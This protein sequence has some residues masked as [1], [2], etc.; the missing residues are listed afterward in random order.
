[1]GCY[2]GIPADTA[3]VEQGRP[4]ANQAVVLHHAAVDHRAVTH[5][6]VVPDDQRRIAVAMAEHQILD[7][8]VFSNPD[9]R[10]V[11]AQH[12]PIPDA[13]ILPNRDIPDNRRIFR[14]PGRGMNLGPF[15]FVRFYNQE[16]PSFSICLHHTRSRPDL[17]IPFSRRSDAGLI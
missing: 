5:G 13:G 12:R 9:C 1:M 4:H 16:I 8:G 6:A 17:Q 10:I 2:Q 15:A 3:V 11:G 14:N 7:V